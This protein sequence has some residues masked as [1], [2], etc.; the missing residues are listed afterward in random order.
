MITKHLKKII[1]LTVVFL[2]FTNIVNA[3]FIEPTVAP[4]SSDQDFLQNILGANNNNN[5][6]DS[7][8]VVA[9]N[10]GSLIERLEYIITSLAALWTKSGDD[11]YYTTG[12]IGIGTTSPVNVDWG[13]A[14]PLVQ[15]SGTQPVLDLEDT[16]GTHF[17]IASASNKLYFMIQQIQQ[18]EC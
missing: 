10:D 6:F 13:S 15:I 3:A 11:L 14:S 9:N 18:L 17:T 4:A 5:D 12:N 1:Y 2:M 7:T 16:G 8:T